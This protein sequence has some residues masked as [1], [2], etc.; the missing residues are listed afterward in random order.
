VV[1]LCWKVR[2]AADIT[3]GVVWTKPSLG[4]VERGGSTANNIVLLDSGNFVFRDANPAAA[5]SARWKMGCSSAAYGSPRR[6]C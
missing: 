4:L 2:I 3:L 5:P 6:G 1:E